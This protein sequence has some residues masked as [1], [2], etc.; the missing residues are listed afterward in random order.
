VLS[1]RVQLRRDDPALE[2]VRGFL[3]DAQSRSV[4]YAG[5]WIPACTPGTDGCFY[6][7]ARCELELN[8]DSTYATPVP[9][10]GSDVYRVVT[11]ATVWGEEGAD[12]LAV[13]VS[14][15]ADHGFDGS[16]IH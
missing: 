1:F 11:K 6:S 16:C 4:V 9:S 8:H 13:Q 5:E 7:W 12:G 10:S 14:A 2:S 3:R 15:T